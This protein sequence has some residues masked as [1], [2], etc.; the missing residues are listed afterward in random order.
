LYLRVPEE[1]S[2]DP[3]AENFTVM[4]GTWKLTVPGGSGWLNAGYQRFRGVIGDAKVSVQIN[5]NRTVA[6]MVKNA[7][8]YGKVSS[9]EGVDVFLITGKNYYWANCD[10][11]ELTQWEA[12]AASSHEE[13]FTANIVKF[14]GTYKYKDYGAVEEYSFT[15]IGSDLSDPT[16]GFSPAMVPSLY[17]D[18]EPVMA[19]ANA[20]EV[21][22]STFTYRKQDAFTKLFMKLDFASGK[23]FCRID[24]KDPVESVKISRNGA[25][26]VVLSFETESAVWNSVNTVP[27]SI[28][29]RLS[30]NDSEYFSG[31]KKELRNWKKL[32]PQDWRKDKKMYLQEANDQHRSQE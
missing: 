18:R 14:K 29:T 1:F 23:W 28:K 12:S 9:T 30:Y 19:G 17:L 26:R 3:G 5:E 13:G 10:V 6:V 27:V 24:G 15:L 21:K 2:F 16:P 11:N 4:L 20:P 7:S 22:D 31:D 32:N 8:L 25:V